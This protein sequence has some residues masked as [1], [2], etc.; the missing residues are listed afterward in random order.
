MTE[1]ERI[2]EGLLLTGLDGANPL[3][4]L[5]ALGTLRGLTIAWPER[6]VCLSWKPQDTWRPCLHVDDGALDEEE[7]LDGLERFMEMRPGHEALEIGVNVTGP[8]I[9][10]PPLP[11]GCGSCKTGPFDDLKVHPEWFRWL[12]LSAAESALPERRAQADFMAAFANDAILNERGSNKG[13]FVDSTQLQLCNGAGHQHFLSRMR[14]LSEVNAVGR[15]N[16]YDCLFSQWQ[17]PD[18]RAWTMRWDPADDRRYALRWD[19]PT[20]QD[21]EGVTEKGA[22]RLAFEALPLF[23]VM[24]IGKMRVT[25]GFSE[26]NR[27]TIWTWPIW[28]VPIGIDVTKSILAISEIQNQTLSPSAQNRLACIGIKQVFRCQWIYGD[29][30]RLSLS[31][32]IPV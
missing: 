17:R 3:A 25:T 4:F 7:V 29:Q 24:P 10:L 21:K 28:D 12:A 31:P 18:T 13:K 15:D 11:K 8:P 23:P 32:A 2:D 14:T 19:D 1:Q 9:H 5:A 26:R 30:G 20:P 16:L 22:N 27:Q 6:R